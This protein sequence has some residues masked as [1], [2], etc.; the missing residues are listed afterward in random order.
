MVTR[1]FWPCFYAA[2]PPSPGVRWCRHAFFLVGNFSLGCCRSFSILSLSPSLPPPPPPLDLQVRTEA[3]KTLGWFLSTFVDE[4]GAGGESGAAAGEKADAQGEGAAAATTG[5]AGG[6]EAG[7][8]TGTLTATT[9]S[10]VGDS[11]VATTATSPSADEDP[12][13]DDIVA[14]MAQMHISDRGATFAQI[15]EVLVETKEEEKRVSGVPDKLL[16]L[17]L[18]MVDP[19]SA[20]SLDVEIGA[21][22]SR[23]TSARTG[24]FFLADGWS[25]RACV[26]CSNTSCAWALAIICRSDWLAIFAT[27]WDKSMYLSALFSPP[28]SPPSAVYYCAFYFPA[29]LLVIGAGRWG[30]VSDLYHTLTTDIQV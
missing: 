29:V 24:S 18:G 10:V 8:G 9:A 20:R 22:S 7:E 11:F 5:E 27:V 28:F 15:E 14:E 1:G 30:D 16:E 2:F 4:E 12:S 26:V 17:Y 19:S 3:Y 6:T 25:T 21:W 13:T 23:Q